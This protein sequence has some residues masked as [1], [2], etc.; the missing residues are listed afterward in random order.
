MQEKDERDDKIKWYNE[1]DVVTI[2]S[3]LKEGEVHIYGVN[4]LMVAG[5]TYKY[6]LEGSV[7]SWSVSMFENK[8]VN[9]L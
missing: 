1:G 2:R 5:R 4:D 7:W 8:E 3:D 9:E 6:L